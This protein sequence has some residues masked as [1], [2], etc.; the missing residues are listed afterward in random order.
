MPPRATERLSLREA[1]K[2]GKLDLLHG[3]ECQRR[4]DS[5]FNGIRLSDYAL[6]CDNATFTFFGQKCLVRRPLCRWSCFDISGRIERFAKEIQEDTGYRILQMSR[7]SGRDAYLLTEKGAVP[8]YEGHPACTYFLERDVI[9][10]TDRQPKAR[11]PACWKFRRL[12]DVSEHSIFIFGE[13][14]CELCQSCCA[15]DQCVL[16][17]TAID[18]ARA[19]VL[20]ARAKEGNH[21]GSVR[22]QL[23]NAGFTVIRPDFGFPDFFAFKKNKVKFVEV[24]G[25]G[26]FVRVHQAV[27]HEAL[28]AAGFAVEVKYVG[29]GGRTNRKGGR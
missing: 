27:V 1:A 4:D 22:R 8:I 19:T 3:K 2:I 26:D 11:C 7:D 6:G 15:A 16:E 12:I 21:E 18:R 28:R 20:A 24:K 9:A 13:H 5:C 29:S 25:P 10:S 23:E 14:A 17:K